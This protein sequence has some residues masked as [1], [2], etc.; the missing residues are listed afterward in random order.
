MYV[1]ACVLCVCVCVFV[2]VIC[3]YAFRMFLFG[4]FVVVGKRKFDGG[5]PNPADIKRRY[6]GGGLIG[7]GGTWASLP[8]P[9]QPLGTNGE[10]WYTD[11]FSTWS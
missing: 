8:L 9:Q 10:Q 1:C 4:D 11:T 3:V 2:Y 5:H 7:N 6:P